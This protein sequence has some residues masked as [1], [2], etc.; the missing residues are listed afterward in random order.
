MSEEGVSLVSCVDSIGT[1][2]WKR[3]AQLLV[4]TFVIVDCRHKS[5]NHVP[6]IWNGSSADQGQ[7]PYQAYLCVTSLP[8]CFGTLFCNWNCGGFCKNF[9]SF[10]AYKYNIT[11]VFHSSLLV[12]NERWVLTAAHCLKYQPLRVLLGTVDNICRKSS[13]CKLLC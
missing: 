12:I 10:L 6:L 7:F 3:F 9:V 2:A 11:F 13:W 5:R 4:L 8:S 1:M